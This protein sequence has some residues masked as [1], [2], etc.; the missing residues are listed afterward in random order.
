MRI[1]LLIS[2]YSIAIFK[3]ALSQ[4]SVIYTVSESNQ[5]DFFNKTLEHVFE[6]KGVS[7]QF[8]NT[9]SNY[10]CWCGNGFGK[11]IFKGKPLDYLD[12]LCKSW[13][14]CIKCESLNGCSGSN[15]DEYKILY[16]F[17][18]DSFSCESDSECGYNRCMCNTV[19]KF[20]LENSVNFEPNKNNF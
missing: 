16:D 6:S 18:N 12:G 5:I 15:K 20:L 19:W 13:T 8:L 11:Q 7:T 9:L 10:G 1:F 4:N 3:S 17:D 2:F 14:Q